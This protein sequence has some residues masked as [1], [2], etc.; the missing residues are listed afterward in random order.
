MVEVGTTPSTAVDELAALGLRIVLY[1]NCARGASILA[2]EAVL[3]RMYVEAADV[4][5]AL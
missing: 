5:R 4:Y 1:E 2:V 3:A